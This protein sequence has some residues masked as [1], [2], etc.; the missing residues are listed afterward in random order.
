LPDSLCKDSP[1]NLIHCG[2]IESA[3]SSSLLGNLF[4]IGKAFSACG[5]NEIRAVWNSKS[6]LILFGA[7]VLQGGCY[8]A[9]DK[10]LKRMRGVIQFNKDSQFFYLVLD[11]R[12]FPLEQKESVWATWYLMV[13][14]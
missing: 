10:S 13:L 14:L 12:A 4:Q 11:N 2:E 7:Y 8:F 6:T 3:Q 5:D 9:C 1:L